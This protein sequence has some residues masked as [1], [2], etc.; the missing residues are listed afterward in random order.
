MVQAFAC[1]GGMCGGKEMNNCLS[2]TMCKAFICF[3]YNISFNSC[4][5]SER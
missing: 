5:I 2:L 3:S 1:E 4:N